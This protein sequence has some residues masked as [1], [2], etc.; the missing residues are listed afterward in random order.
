MLSLDDPTWA[1]LS[2]AY[3]PASDVPELLR[4]LA[5]STR[6]HESHQE[7]PWFSL[8]SSLCHQ[9]D[10]Y[11]AS[12][13]AVPHIV[14]IALVT[15]GPLDFSFFQLPACIEIARQNGR[16]PELSIGLGVSYLSALAKLSECASV[17]LSDEWDD[18]MLLST[19]AAIAVAKGKYR[20]AEAIVN[21]DDHL[22]DK[23]IDLDFS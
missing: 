13:A 1:Q 21:L 17:H 10:V 20:I 5:Q 2:H 18:N 22:I 8:W 11:E 9:G 15:P 19:L 4:K 6:Q 3:G 23:L 7:E 12:Y 16:G 14:E